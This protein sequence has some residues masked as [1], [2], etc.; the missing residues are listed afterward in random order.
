MKTP[1]RH[2]HRS[3][4]YNSGLLTQQNVVSANSLLNDAI[5][6]SEL[7]QSLHIDGDDIIPFVAVSGSDLET[8]QISILKFMDNVCNVS[9][10]PSG[11]N[12][13]FD[14]N[15]NTLYISTSPT[16]SYSSLRVNNIPVS[17]NGHTHTLSDITNFTST[18]T[19]LI[20]PDAP[21]NNNSYV[22]KNN[23]WVNIST[24]TNFRFFDIY[25]PQNTGIIPLNAEPFWNSYNNRL[26]VGDGIT[27]GGIEVGP[28]LP[29]RV[30]SID[31][32]AETTLS[33][34]TD[35]PPQ[36]VRVSAS[37]P[38]FLGGILA[39]GSNSLAEGG[40][41]ASY[42]LLLINIGSHTITIKHQMPAD[43]NDPIERNRI[44]TPNSSDYLLV[45]G[46]SI[47]LFYDTVVERWRV[48]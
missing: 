24:P 43:L 38:F 44:I 23:A 1:Q 25:S 12:I 21:S 48:V 30:T 37:Q 11:D 45:G 19:S 32:I 8:K 40:S 2:I 4:N 20:P 7:P 42:E 9:L 39:P 14:F 6:I 3:Y 47:R 18:I 46:F 15:N 31:S 35:P 29:L 34:P 10:L 28:A 26:I 36:V 16:G 22:R 13:K 17:I 5:K 27:P 33:I 41:L